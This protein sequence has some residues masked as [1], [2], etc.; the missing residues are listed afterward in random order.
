MLV[1]RP[2]TDV[3]SGPHPRIACLP[4]D[5][6]RL[7]TLDSGGILRD[8]KYPLHHQPRVFDTSFD[9]KTDTPARKRPD[10]DSDSQ[11]LRWDHELLWTKE[12]SP[13]VL[14]APK[15]TTRKREYLIYTDATGERSC[16]G[17]DAITSSYSGR[18]RPASLAGAMAGL[19]E[20]QRSV[21]HHPHYTIGSAMIWPV[22]S[23]KVSINQARGFGRTGQM[24]GDRMDLTLECIRRHYTELTGEGPGG[25]FRDAYWEFLAVIDSCKDFFELFGHQEEGFRAFVDFF[26]LQD[27]TTPDYKQVRH[28]L[29]FDNFQSSGLPASTADYVT[30][31]NATLEFIS[32]RGRR[33]AEWVSR[34]H[35]DI[36]V[37][38]PWWRPSRK[39]LSS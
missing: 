6:H 33:M 35:P 18:S 21:Y 19:S 11:L 4:Y 39:G 12:L 31:R 20:D 27:L 29:P 26:H 1:H 28:F 8:L 37:R 5:G 17:S 36:E 32:G 24:I 2:A 3:R 15:V 34:N 16:Y 30:Y 25:E 9:Y 10:A 38:C 7:I 14:F 13:G 22:K 23:G